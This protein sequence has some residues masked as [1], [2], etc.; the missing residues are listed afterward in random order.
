MKLYREMRGVIFS[1]AVLTGNGAMMV[2]AAPDSLLPHSLSNVAQVAAA[3]TSSESFS[4]PTLEMALQMWRMF[5][6]REA[7]RLAARCDDYQEDL[8]TTPTFYH[9]IRDSRNR[10]VK[11]ARIIEPS[12]KSL[13]VPVL[14]VGDAFGRQPRG[15]LSGKIVFCSG[16]HGWTCDVTST[17]LWYTQRPLSF[18]IVEDYGNIDQLNLFADVAWRAG[19]TIIPFRPLGHQPIERVLDNADKSHVKFDG[20]WFDS[21]SAIYYGTAHDKVPYRFAVASTTDT[22]RAVYRP[23]LPKADYYPVYCWVRD[24]ADRVPQTY[25]IF[26]AGGV[27]EVQVDHRRVGKGWVYLGEYYFNRGWDGF[28][29]ISNVVSDPSLADGRHVVI[30]DAIRFGNGM[31]DVDRGGGVSGYPR[32]EEASRYWVERMLP[33]AAPPIFDPFEATDQDSNVGCPPRMSAYMNRES[34]GSFFDR[35]YVGFHTNA[36]GGR[37]AVGL[38]EKDEDKRTDHQVEFAQLVAQQLNEDMSTTRSFSWAAPWNVRKKTTDSHINFGEIRRDALNNEMCAT[39]L[40]AAF[41]DEPLDA[42]LIR[43]PRFRTVVAEA[44]TKAILRFFKSQNAL[45]GDD[46]IPPHPPRFLVAQAQTSSS[47]LLKWEASEDDAQRSTMSYRLYHSPDGFAFGAIAD[48]GQTTGI[49]VAGLEPGLSHYFRVAAYDGSGESAPS[50]V[51]GARSTGTTTASRHLVVSAFTTFSEDV[52]LSQSV[53]AGLGSPLRG[54]GE[55]VRVIPRKMNAGNYVAHWGTALA[56]V[57]GEFDSCD[58]AALGS[59]ALSATSYTSV[60]IA[61]GKQSPK[62][63]SFNPAL[64]E[65]LDDFRKQGGAIV[66]SGTNVAR[67]LRPLKSASESKPSKK[68]LSFYSWCPVATTESLIVRSVVGQGATEFASAEFTL[69]GG[70]GD[71]Y[72]ATGCDGLHLAGSKALLVYSTGARETAL[73]YLPRTARVGSAVFAGFPLECIQPATA[74]NDAFARLIKLL[75]AA[76]SK[77][78]PGKTT[79]QKKTK[80]S[81]TRQ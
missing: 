75:G 65:K 79:S 23:F 6:S 48:V 59:L 69:D 19:A 37:G 18:G 66:V 60:M 68:A 43:D 56:A 8:Q 55:F 27:T 44:T 40:E 74:R 52:V 5:V 41:H 4:S 21:R 45:G 34:E 38:F 15:S 29:E 39:I 25:R 46:K 50:R 32:E 72:P 9:E 12:E 53:P 49:V 28:V 14:K 47:V 76:E 26:H 63:S 42:S 57:G 73:L 35:I 54:G 31:G 1:L 13:G 64:L 20:N 62:E 81:A 61:L 77:G 11:P 3:R 67:C 10:V 33:V 22:A 7:A 2:H 70:E 24:G 30:A 71:A 16:G 80:T 58:I 78:R 36:V 51:L 17:S